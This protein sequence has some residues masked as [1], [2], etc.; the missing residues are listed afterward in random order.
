V[1][2]TLA[3][4]CVLDST[5][6]TW[7]DDSAMD[8]MTSADTVV[9]ATIEAAGAIG[10]AAY[11]VEGIATLGIPEL[12]IGAG[13]E[14]S[15]SWDA[16]A[17]HSTTGRGFYRSFHLAYPAGFSPPGTGLML[18]SNFTI[19]IEGEV[20]LY[21]GGSSIELT[22][23]DRGFFDL[24]D[25]GTGSYFRVVS[26]ASASGLPS[27]GVV[28][29][30]ADGWYGFRGAF[31]QE[32][33]ATGYHIRIADPGGS[34]SDVPPT[35]LRIRADALTGLAIDGFGL[36]F[37]AGP[38]GTSLAT[39][40]LANQEYVV[41][42]PDVGDLGFGSWSARWAGQVLVTNRGHYAFQL[43]TRGGHRMWIDSIPLAGTNDATE[44]QLTTTPPLDLEPGWHDIVVD[45][46]RQGAT[47]ED[48][49]FRLTIAS[50][51]EF[52]GA[53]FPLDRLRPVIGRGVRWASPE[54]TSS[55]AI[56]DGGTIAKALNVQIP[57]DDGM[58]MIVDFWWSIN[59]TALSTVGM[60]L[61]RP[62]AT[63]I[64]FGALTGT[65]FATGRRHYES[66]PA[67]GTWTFGVSDNTTDGMTGS[68]LA[69][70]V[71][72]TYKGG[73][74]PCAPR[75]TYTSRIRNL[76]PALAIGGVRWQTRQERDGGL[77]RVSVR[78]CDT[79]ACANEVWHA[80]EQSGDSAGV[81]A[82]PFLQYM[83]EITTNG[84]VPTALEWIEIDYRL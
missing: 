36:A 74:A 67:Q 45:T 22:A 18:T 8:F 80:V 37:L 57:S 41:Y 15:V 53:F 68:I 60:T 50:G 13:N 9:D 1:C 24:V 52:V 61:T 48:S 69:E 32:G 6:E 55:V 58:A 73:T 29:V 75:A 66:I 42:P 5:L 14:S 12:A 82:R 51:P 77:V 17:A 34:L 39:T 30:A 83:V 4:V 49:Y 64:P 40:S 28:T 71:A 72:V 16:I 20:Y 59:H 27:T 56:P 78:T 44:P 11:F 81:P 10:P 3:N 38:M 7:R 47:E 46:M 31:E 63:T 62:P 54:S 76:G 43:D 65:G 25:P 70:R 23:D 26:N 2:D 35:R 21:A 79:E 19:R 33:D 84:D